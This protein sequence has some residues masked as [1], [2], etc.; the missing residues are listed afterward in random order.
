MRDVE[1][2]CRNTSLREWCTVE[3]ISRH[4]EAMVSHVHAMQPAEKQLGIVRCLS[5]TGVQAECGW[6]MLELVFSAVV[7]GAFSRFL[8]TSIS[9]SP[10]SVGALTVHRIPLPEVCCMCIIVW[11]H[12][13]NGVLHKWKE[14]DH[15]L[16]CFGQDKLTWFRGR[17]NNDFFSPKGKQYYHA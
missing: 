9:V 10:R 4:V 8:S 5:S 12:S 15:E 1:I 3:G 13:W 7:C 17:A 2:F 16:G 14:P 6:R 11:S